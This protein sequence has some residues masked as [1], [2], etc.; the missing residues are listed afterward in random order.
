MNAT[1]PMPI[2]MRLSLMMFLQFFVWGAWYVTMGTYLGEIGFSGTDIG[3]AYAT[4]SLGAIVSPFLVGMIADRFFAA[5]KVLGVAHILG[6]VALYGASQFTEPGAF[7]WVLLAHALLYMPTLA[8]VN[9]VAFHQ[10]QDP[11]K[12]FPAVRVLGTIG[13]IVAGWVAAKMGESTATPMLVGAGASIALGLYSFSLP[14][15]PPKSRGKKVTFADVLGL[16]ALVLFKDRSF[17]ILVVSSLLISIPLAFYYSF[18]NKFLNDVGMPDAAGQM[19][20]GQ[21]SEIVFMLAIP[22]FLGRLG[23]KKTMILG[24]VAWA[25]RYVFFAVGTSGPSMSL[26]LAGIVLHGVCYDFFFVSGQI[27]VDR[28]AP[29]AIQASAQGLITLVTYG[30]GMAIGTA[31]SG[32]VV[33]AY[34]GD[35]SK[36]WYVPAAAAAGVAIL[37]TLF[38]KEDMKKPAKA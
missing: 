6:G 35:W 18:T 10:M 27:Y 15:T 20:Y 37:F 29:K 31:F 13:W 8:L 1:M 2:R 5:E 17:A 38:F 7:F 30:I 3:E 34:Q 22:F 14:A 11:G 24:M 28:K 4:M 33:D 23:I 16:E 25:A 9:A 36:I 19:T 21:V 12:Q 26:L 32:R